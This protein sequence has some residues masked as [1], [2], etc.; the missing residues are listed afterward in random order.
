VLRLAAEISDLEAIQADLVQLKAATKF[1]RAL[2]DAGHWGFRPERLR[3]L[4]AI[5]VRARALK[6]SRH[7]CAD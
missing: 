1:E 5:Y 7:H 2:R 4:L 6:T 3:R